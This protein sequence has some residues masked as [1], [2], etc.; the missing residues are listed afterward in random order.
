M[1]N[2]RNNKSIHSLLRRQLS[3]GITYLSTATIGD[4]IDF[5]I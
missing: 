5:L 1:I 3:I 2:N 4:I